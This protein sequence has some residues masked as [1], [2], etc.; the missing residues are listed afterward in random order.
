MGVYHDVHAVFMEEDP[1]IQE[2]HH[3]AGTP[4]SVVV[5][6]FISDGLHSFEDIPVMLGA[7]PDAV[8]ER[9]RRGEPTW[10][11]PTE[12][13]GR[14]VWYTRSIGDES[15]IPDVVLERVRE[16]ALLPAVL[17]PGEAPGMRRVA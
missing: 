10:I 8:Q 6:F 7:S 13:Q 17:T 15:H 1:R 5:P 2:V 12:I 11:N 4:N 14:R 3:L 9:L 16:S